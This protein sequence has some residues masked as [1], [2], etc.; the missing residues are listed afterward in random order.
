MEVCG[1]VRQSQ[2]PAQPSQ[3]VKASHL[4]QAALCSVQTI[5]LRATGAF[6]LRPLGKG[7]PSGLFSEVVLH[8]GLLVTCRIDF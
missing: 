8:L 5:F 2:C 1:P 3:D 7:V 4:S 6:S